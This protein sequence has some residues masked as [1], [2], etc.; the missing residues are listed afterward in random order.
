M[1]LETKDDIY[2]LEVG[3][4]EFDAAEWA[5]IAV[6]VEHGDL[7]PFHLGGYDEIGTTETEGIVRLVKNAHSRRFDKATEGR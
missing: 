2:S 5:E 3:T 6:Y 7:G 4:D 1:Q